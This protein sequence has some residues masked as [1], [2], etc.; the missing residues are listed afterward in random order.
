MENPTTSSGLPQLKIN[1][2]TSPKD[3]FLHLLAIVAL[4]TSAIS[5]SILVFQYINIYLPDALDSGFYYARGIMSLIRNSLATLIVFFPVYLFSIRHLNKEY[6]RNPEKKELRIRKWLIYFTLFAA[7]L[8][9]MGDLVA[10]IRNFLEG[11]LTARFLLK[12]LTIGFVAGSVFNYYFSELKN[13]SVKVFSYL[14]IGIIAVIVVGGFFVAGSPSEERARRFDDQRVQDLQFIQSEVIFH[15]QNKGAL[16]ENL[17][18]LNNA[19]RGIFIP[20]DPETD[21][22]YGYQ[23]TGEL[24]FELCANFNVAGDTS[25]PLSVRTEFYYPKPVAVNDAQNA[26]NH[27][28]G[29]SCFK[30]TIDPDFYKPIN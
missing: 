16:P 28:A 18:V 21:E 13:K 14:V 1:P 24:D 7:A 22:N 5:L 30:R 29:P 3:F 4:Y 27:E 6:F 26:W 10:L 12:V 11:E 23:V 9:I 8:I 19:T 15:W 17:E 20:G 2:K 25:D